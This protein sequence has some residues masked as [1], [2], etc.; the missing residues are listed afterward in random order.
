MKRVVRFGAGKS[1]PDG[2]TRKYREPSGNR[3]AVVIRLP[4]KSAKHIGVRPVPETDTGG[5][6]EYT[7]ALERFTVKELGKLTP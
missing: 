3:I 2:E 6:V 4:R 7:E 5:R 1:T